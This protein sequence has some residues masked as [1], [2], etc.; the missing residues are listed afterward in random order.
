MG[1]AALVAIATAPWDRE[2]VNN[3]FNIPTTLFESGNMIGQFAFQ[4]TA[5]FA[6][7]GV[8]KAVG[9]DKAA[10]RRAAISCVPSCSHRRWYRP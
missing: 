4:M 3:G 9:N 5:G 2:G 7:Y 8:G 6:T 1:Y 10:A